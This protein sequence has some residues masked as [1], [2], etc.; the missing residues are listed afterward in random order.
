MILL[1]FLLASLVSAGGGMRLGLDACE[2]TVFIV[3]DGVTGTKSRGKGFGPG[4]E[5][6]DARK[7]DTGHGTAVFKSLPECMQENVVPIK[8]VGTGKP[9][10]DRAVAWMKRF[11]GASYVYT[12]LDLGIDEHHVEFNVEYVVSYYS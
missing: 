7:D 11:S 8:I 2:R 12:T 1:P 6:V 3:G 10:I 9:E 5:Y 4:T